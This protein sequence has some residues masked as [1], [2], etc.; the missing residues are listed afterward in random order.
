MNPVTVRDIYFFGGKI[1]ADGFCTLTFFTLRD[2]AVI[3][4]FT[5]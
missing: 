4:N 1:I 3:V 5:R 2:R